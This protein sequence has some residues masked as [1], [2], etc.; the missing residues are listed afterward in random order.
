M[1]PGNG[2]PKRPKTIGQTWRIQRAGPQQPAGGELPKLPDWP[3]LPEEKPTDQWPSLGSWPPASPN[4]PDAA[5]STS[6]TD[7]PATGSHPRGRDRLRALRRLRIPPRRA[8]LALGLGAIVLMIVA[9]SLALA[10]RVPGGVNLAGAPPSGS[11]ASQTATG[12][13]TTALP[14]VSP[15]AATSTPAPTQP[16]AL[17]L[18]FTCASGQLHGTGKVC[19]HTLPRASLSITVRYCNGAEARGLHSGVTAD[20]DGNYTWTWHIRTACVGTATATV[21]AKWQGQSVT[22]SETFTINP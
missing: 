20:A 15:Q 22:S 17:S 6:T 2:G 8:V 9:L 1:E 10:A 13:T 18:T 5:A 4:G 19:V 3:P 21:T 11:Q 16:P 7:G 14:T 12:A